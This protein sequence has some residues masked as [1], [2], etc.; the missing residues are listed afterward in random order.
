MFEWL[1]Q[2]IATI[3]IS[4]VLVGICT[5]IVIRMIKNKKKGK[6]SCGC[7]CANCPMSGECQSRH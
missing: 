5:A 4:I 2:N 3:A 1:K 6:S 7:G